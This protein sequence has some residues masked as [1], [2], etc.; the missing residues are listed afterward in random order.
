MSK[1]VR[2]KSNGRNS[3]WL[4]EGKIYQR[5]RVIANGFPLKWVW[6]LIALIAA[7]LYA[8][9]CSQLADQ[10]A[11]TWNAP[12]EDGLRASFDVFGEGKRVTCVVDG[13]TFWL[14]GQKF[15]IADIDTPELSPPRCEAERMKGEAAKKRL[16]ELLSA[17]SFSLVAGWRD[18]DKHGRKLRTVI[19]D[20]RSIGDVLVREGLARPWDGARRGWCT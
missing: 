16:R 1:I 5:K 3:P 7:G 15:R 2:F 13:D 10:L 9:E 14:S 8:A 20:G 17:E 18:E 12:E 11:M 6:A 19:R 4:S